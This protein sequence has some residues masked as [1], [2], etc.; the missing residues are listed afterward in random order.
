MRKVSMDS[1]NK[2]CQELIDGLILKRNSMRQASI[3]A[4]IL[5]VISSFNA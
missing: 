1:A 5:E 4:E 2:N 3:T